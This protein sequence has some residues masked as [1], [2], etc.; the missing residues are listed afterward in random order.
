MIDCGKKVSVNN[1]ILTLRKN[2]CFYKNQ[3]W[4]YQ[5]PQRYIESATEDPV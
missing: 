4:A 5:G 2:T 1:K 3:S